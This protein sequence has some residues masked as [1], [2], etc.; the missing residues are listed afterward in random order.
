[1]LVCWPGAWLTAR[2]LAVS[3]VTGL[4]TAVLVSS[5]LLIRQLNEPQTTFPPYLLACT[6]ALSLGAGAT[7]LLAPAVWPPG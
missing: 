2:H 5:P 1:M 4:V 7:G 3:R 6:L